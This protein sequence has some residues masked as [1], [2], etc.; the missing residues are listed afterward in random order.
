[1]NQ[2]KIAPVIFLNTGRCGSTMVSEIMNCHPRI[3]SI[4]ELFFLAGNDRSCQGPPRWRGNVE[5]L[6]PSEFI[7]FHDDDDDGHPRHAQ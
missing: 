4:S 7:L 3:L 1:M 5:N 2:N 6:Q